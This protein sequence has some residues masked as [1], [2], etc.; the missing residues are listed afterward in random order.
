MS[1]AAHATRTSQRRSKNSSTFPRLKSDILSFQSEE[2]PRFSVSSTESGAD[3]LL[4]SA[5]ALRNGGGSE[6]V[7]V[8]V[9]TDRDGKSNCFL[10]D[11]NNS[12]LQFFAVCMCIQSKTRQKGKLVVVFLYR[13][14]AVREKQ[15][16]RLPQDECKLRALRTC[17][18]MRRGAPKKLDKLSHESRHLTVLKERFF[19]LTSM[20]ID[21]R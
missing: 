1:R 9:D 17:R 4:L 11:S 2:A 5:S 16:P 6:D 8:W 13:S 20:L 21:W 3:R 10:S 14:G 7:F 18:D 12:W 19:N 15:M